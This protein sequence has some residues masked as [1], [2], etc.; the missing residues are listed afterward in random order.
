MAASSSLTASAPHFCC[1]RRRGVSGVGVS[2][3]WSCKFRETGKHTA[4]SKRYFQRIDQKAS[5]TI[6]SRT[7]QFR[8]RATT[9]EVALA[10]ETLLTGEEAVITAAAAEAVA[11]ARAAFEV[12][13]EAVQLSE[14]SDFSNKPGPQALS[15][16]STLSIT[17]KIFQNS[18]DG[19]TIQI[20][21]KVSSS[22]DYAKVQLSETS[23]FSNKPGPQALS[24]ESTLSITDKIFQ[25]LFDGVTIQ[26]QEKVSSSG[27]YVKVQLSE[28]S[29]FSNKP[30][31]Q[32][33]LESTLSITDKIFQNPFDGDTIQIQE[34]VSTSVDY[35][36]V[37][38]AST[39]QDERRARRQR[40]AEKVVGVA[41][42]KLG[43][44][45]KKTQIF[46]ENDSKDP[47]KMFKRIA[48]A[49]KALTMEEEKELSEGVQD[50]LSLKAIEKE[51]TEQHGQDPSFAMWAAAAQIDQRTLRRRLEHGMRCREKMIKCNIRLVV[52]IARKSAGA[53]FALG[54]L[55]QEGCQGMVKAVE[56]FDG[57]RGFKFSTYAHWWIKQS[58][59]K[60]L[61]EKSRLI[62]L[63]LS[64][65]KASY[66]VRE[67]IKELRR[68]GRKLKDIDTAEIAKLAR[69][70]EKK[71]KKVMLLP[72]TPKSLDAMIGLDKNVKL[73]DTIPCHEED[74]LSYIMNKEFTKAGIKRVLDTLT[75][76]EKMVVRCRYGL[77]DGRA[78]TLQEIGDTLGISRERVRQ[79]E[80]CAFRKLKSKNRIELLEGYIKAYGP[81]Y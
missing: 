45:K 70:T 38:V 80:S 50:L 31:P 56:K 24:L 4:S 16:E 12:A 60:Y 11:L 72:K 28:T 37:K 49:Y 17:D 27:D 63:P 68:S 47:V 15:L 19:G 53:G 57:S 7:T 44:G 14:T 71:V 66:R 54:D 2:P 20:Q 18:F 43:V 81:G 58:I 21:E 67:A 78:K 10:N 46:S 65:V 59:R 29:D 51:L 6:I 22:V 61:S 55:V 1:P 3:L 69:V 52:S 77:E 74:S 30:G 34:K 42:V 32:A 26:I 9:M 64:M 35:V 5:L 36:K 76:R 75:A 33:S 25:N 48:G 13:Q 23:D 8:C 41:T 39:R 73:S 62:H 79:I 40:A